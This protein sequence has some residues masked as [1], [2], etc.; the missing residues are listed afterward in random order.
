[1]VGKVINLS[2]ISDQVK[3]QGLMTIEYIKLGKF[4]II[5]SLVSGLGKFF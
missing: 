1:L 3:E 2:G 5:D 4:E